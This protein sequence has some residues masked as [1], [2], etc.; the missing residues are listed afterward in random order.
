M[1]LL[2]G[3]ELSQAFDRGASAYDRLIA[4]NPGYHRALRR[5]ARRLA[6]PDLGAGLRLL[7]LGCGTGSSTAALLRS[8][9]RARITAVDASA[10][11][12]AQAA[13]K[14]WPSTVRF[15]HS[16][17][18]ELSGTGEAGPYDAVFAAYLVRNAADPGA[19]LDAVHRMLRPG[20]R[21]AVHEYALSG[22]AVHRAV[23]SAV[24]GGVVLPLGAVSGGGT[25][26]YRHLWRSVLDF[27]TAG[28]F[29]ERLA[30]HGFAGARSSPMTGWQHGV[31]H[32]FTARRPGG[33]F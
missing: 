8:Y 27:D 19:V 17:V 20:G 6:L 14:R 3:A 11:M 32:T 30:R 24:C 4:I 22:R 28:R 7:D 16:P 25:A 18:E 13:E 15:V 29:T 33:E 26:L 9:P 21:L 2:Q 5:S 31:V 12:L 1:T 23:W 10:G